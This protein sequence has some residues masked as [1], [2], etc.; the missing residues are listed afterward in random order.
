M[1]ATHIILFIV[2]TF[3]I[4]A[5]DFTLAEDITPP[6]NYVSPTPEPTL[7]PLYPAQAPDVDKG[8]AIYAEKCAPCHGE[9][10][11]GDGRQGIQ[12]NVT[13][14]AF[15]LSE[16]ARPAS[17]A[18]WYAMV[19]RGNIE[20]FM[21][22]FLSLSD[23]ERWDVA[24]YAMTLHTTREELAL[25]KEL[26]ET[27]CANCSTDFFRDQ[28][29]MS[30]LSEVDLARIIK[31][32]NDKV[33]AFGENLNEDEVWLVAAYL[34]TL[35]LAVPFVVSASSSLTPTEPIPASQTSAAAERTPP[36]TAQAA[37][38][39][40]ATVIAQ[41]GFGTVHGSVENK[42]GLKL[43]PNQKVTLRGFDHSTD[44]NT[45]PKE[46]LSLDGTLNADGIFDFED[47]EMP[48]GR[49]F[50]AQIVYEG[51]TLQ[52]D[53][54]VVEE[55]NTSLNLSPIKL[56]GTTDDPSSLVIDEA[57]I[58]FDYTENE[59]Q[60]FSVYSFRNQTD[61]IIAVPLKG[62][63]EI[64]FLKSPQD[65]QVQGFE[66]MQ[67]SQPFTSAGN[68]L[69]F[70]PN[71][72]PYGLIVFS[73]LPK[74]TQIEVIQPFVLPISSLTVF[75]PEGVQADN[76]Q[77][78]DHGV[79][80]IDNFNFQMYAAG[81][82]KAGSTLNFTLSGTPVDRAES[83]STTS[84]NTKKSILIGASALGLTL[85]LVGA[86]LFIKDRKHR[87]SSHQDAYKEFDTPE[88]VMDAIIALDDLNQA[89]KISKDVYQKR[90]NKLKDQ[91]KEM[92]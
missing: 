43:S 18:K 35:S 61:K 30:A 74:G 88:E 13:V 7:G 41:P 2:A 27:N 33:K 10:G 34:R 51:I 44:P 9:T 22:P 28:S 37:V 49:I 76:S 81:D 3:T 87:V 23:Q 84:S 15:G 58:F 62:G 48:K 66:P 54:A 24:A 4:S 68:T 14:P 1:K 32:G 11:M 83:T 67:D 73:T 85:I 25:G 8:A 42:T 39:N 6:P 77:L 86:W 64:P 69:A 36:S 72:K 26:F 31:E 20:R 17:L 56:Y 91:L 52:S 89:K 5:C 50:M 19:T 75:L 40:E 65:A 53:F 60:V 45:N 12:L 82:L 46:V 80:K 57:R 78:A 92:M 63:L 16:V 29:K 79:Q 90:R 70:P 21:P 71:E 59:I 47:I 55:G 38:T